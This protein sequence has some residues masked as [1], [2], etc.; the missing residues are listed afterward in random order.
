MQILLLLAALALL[1]GIVVTIAGLR[2]APM[3]YEDAE[4]FHMTAT[5]EQVA[6]IEVLPQSHRDAE[7]HDAPGATPHAA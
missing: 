5:A 2:R 6:A 4:G 7:E 1:A 3:G